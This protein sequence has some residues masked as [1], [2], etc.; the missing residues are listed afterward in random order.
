MEEARIE[1]AGDQT[2][3]RE[4]VLSGIARLVRENGIFSTFGGLPAML[5]KQV[6]TALNPALNPAVFNCIILHCTVLLFVVLICSIVIYGAALYLLYY[7]A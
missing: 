4:N 2:W 5:A 7:S 6:R 3:A 1:M